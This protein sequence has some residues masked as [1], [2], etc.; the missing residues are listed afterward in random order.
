MLKCINEVSY[1]CKS[2]CNHLMSHAT[3]S[4]SN[5]TIYRIGWVYVLDS[6]NEWDQENQ[7]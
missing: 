2:M 5:P 6:V 7:I 4:Y 3:V 1:G